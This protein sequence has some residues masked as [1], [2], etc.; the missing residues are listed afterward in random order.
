[1]A[2]VQQPKPPRRAAAL[3]YDP[4]QS[5]AP[6]VVAAGQG[7]LASQILAEAESAGVPI[8]EHPGLAHALVGL[9]VGAEIPPDL[10]ATVA[11]V[12]AW[13]AEVD[14]ERSENWFRTS[15][16]VTGPRKPDAAAATPHRP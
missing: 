2:E 1:M 9:G 4:K 13:V 6:V 7:E 11:E 10:Y 15:P 16:T 14:Q 5:A 3:K 8:Y 12:L